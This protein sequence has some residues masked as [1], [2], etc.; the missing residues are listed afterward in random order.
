[1]EF[2]LC[3]GDKI[4]DRLE[5]LLLDHL[6]HEAAAFSTAV[7]EG[8]KVVADALR[9]KGD[10][11]I[12]AGGDEVLASSAV[13]FPDD[14]LEELRKIFRARTGCS[15]SMGVGISPSQ[16]LASLHRAKLLGKDRFI[17]GS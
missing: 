15:M 11:V 10:E 4:G 8:T 13:G 2:L 3:D 1:M 14:F 5:L 16:A 17:R 12:F 6:L 9:S 7:S